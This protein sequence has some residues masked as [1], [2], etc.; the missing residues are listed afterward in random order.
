MNMHFVKQMKA[1][2]FYKMNA[3]DGGLLV[4]VGFDRTLFGCFLSRVRGM[5]V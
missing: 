1:D 3:F 4:Y 2:N 5:G